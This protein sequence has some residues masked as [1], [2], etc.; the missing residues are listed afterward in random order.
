MNRVAQLRY[1]FLVTPPT[2]P[3]LLKRVCDK[4]QNNSWNIL[5]QSPLLSKVYKRLSI[6]CPYKMALYFV[7]MI[8]CVKIEYLIRWNSIIHY[9]SSPEKIIVKAGRGGSRKKIPYFFT[10]HANQSDSRSIT[11]LKNYAQPLPIE[12]IISNHM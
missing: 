8:S 6:Y 10:V 5:G 9:L 4:F 12:M 3:T 7:K 2:K 11:P 1:N